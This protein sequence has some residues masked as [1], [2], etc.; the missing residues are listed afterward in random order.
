[1]LQTRRRSLGLLRFVT[2]RH[3]SSD[4][5]QTNVT[6]DYIIRSPA[7]LQQIWSGNF[8]EFCLQGIA[9]KQDKV[10]LVCSDTGR[11]MTFGQYRDSMARWGGLLSKQGL[12]P[13]DVVAFY[14]PNS[15]DANC[16]VYGTIAA[17]CIY[18]GINPLC[19]PTEVAHSIS[20]SGARM[21][22]F[23]GPLEPDV[24]KALE[25]AHLNIPLFS[26]GASSSGTAPRVEEILADPRVEFSDPHERT[27]EETMAFMY[28]SG[29]TGPPKAVAIS[30]NA[31]IAS[32]VMR[33]HPMFRIKAIVRDPSDVCMTQLFPLF[34]ISGLISSGGT[35]LKEGFRL[36]SINR[37]NPAN[38]LDKIFKYKASCVHLLPSLMNYALSQPKFN[39]DNCSHIDAIITGAAPVPMCSVERVMERVGPQAK[40]IQGYGMTEMLVVAQDPVRETRPGFTGQLLPGLEAKIVDVETGQTLSPDKS[41]EIYLKGPTM[42]SGYHNDCSKTRDAIDEDGWYHSGDVGHFDQDGFLKVVDRTKELIKVNAL[43]VSPSELEEVLLR[44]PEV[45]DVGV[46]GVLHHKTG[47]APRAYVKTFAPLEEKKIHDHMAKYCARYKHLTGGIRFVDAI[48]RTASGKIIKRELLK[49]D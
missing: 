40:F 48:P 16:V 47:E 38:F 24:R 33:T 35:A 2:R 26:I 46:V 23:S 8:V 37:F 13:G 7:S 42:M 14:T 5:R 20:D 28:S 3:A 4:S 18:T 29:T 21:I 12:R 45:V 43:Q 39:P 36:V 30:H 34:H 9:E 41:G 19:T 44:M 15:I 11:S 1:M 49:L 17:G 31:A 10:A 27:G 6:P 25:I 32:V 22:V